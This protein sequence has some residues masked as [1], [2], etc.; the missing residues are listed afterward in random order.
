MTSCD[1]PCLVAKDSMVWIGRGEHNY[2]F[3][4]NLRLEIGSWRLG[5]DL[6]VSPRPVDGIAVARRWCVRIPRTRPGA[7]RAEGELSALKAYVE[8]TR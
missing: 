6:P 8:G 1:R 7:C 2:G 5:V 3:G 4:T